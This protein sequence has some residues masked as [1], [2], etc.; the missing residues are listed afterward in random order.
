MNDLEKNLLLR[1]KQ[2]DRKAFDR[3]FEDNFE[4]LC[5]YAFLLVRDETAAEEIATEV[6]YSLW[7]KRNEIH[8]RVSIKKYLIKSVYNVS[9]NYLKHIGVVKHYKDLSIVMHKEK[10]IFSGDYRTSPL[11]ILEYDELES[12][13]NEVIDNLPDQCRQVFTM[14]RFEGMK[15]RE[16]AQAL[17]ISLSTVK[18]H[19]SKAL[20]ALKD[21]MSVYLDR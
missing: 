11:A 4:N 20:N 19:M 15:Y 10:E 17:N 5:K 13:I 14:N 3:L 9:M 7:C 18:Y 16:I 21:E 2:G 6:F 8:I 12:L 1:I